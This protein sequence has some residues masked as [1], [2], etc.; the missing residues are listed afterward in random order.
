MIVAC[1]CVGLLLLA[2]YLL[3]GIN[4]KNITYDNAPM[5]PIYKPL[6]VIFWPIAVMIIFVIGIYEFFM[7]WVEECK[8]YYKKEKEKENE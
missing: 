7:I 3:I 4:V 8:E 2:I 5:S 1:V 6:I